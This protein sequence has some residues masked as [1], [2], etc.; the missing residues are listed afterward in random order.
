[1]EWRRKAAEAE[2]EAAGGSVPSPRP[3]PPKQLFE[4][5]AAPTAASGPVRSS[6]SDLQRELDRVRGRSMVKRSDRPTRSK[7]MNRPTATDGAAAAESGS[8]GETVRKVLFPD[9]AET[10][11]RRV[12]RRRELIHQHENPQKPTPLM[13]LNVEVRSD[14]N[15]KVRSEKQSKSMNRLMGHSEKEECTRTVRFI[16]AGSESTHCQQQG[17]KPKRLTISI[18][19][20]C[21]QPDAVANDTT[22]AVGASH[23][24][25]TAN[26]ATFLTGIGR[27]LG[28]RFLLPPG[29]KTMEREEKKIWDE[30][31][32]T[33]KQ[34]VLPLMA[35][36]FRLN[37][38][39]WRKAP[40]NWPCP[41]QTDVDTLTDWL[42]F[43]RQVR[44]DEQF[45]DAE[46]P[47]RKLTHVLHYTKTLEEC[48]RTC[49]WRI[50]LPDGFYGRTKEDIPP[51]M[52]RWCQH[53]LETVPKQKRPNP[54]EGW[55]SAEDWS[56]EFRLY[57]ARRQVQ[58]GTTEEETQWTRDRNRMLRT[59]KSSEI[60]IPDVVAG[61]LI[62][63]DFTIAARRAYMALG[64]HEGVTR[65]Y[66]ETEHEMW[67]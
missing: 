60:L 34:K 20:D 28:N 40:E 18:F 6:V 4:T 36:T 19:P 27:G 45:A 46:P 61:C 38:R 16:P 47:T 63:R 67:N 66:H 42:K 30:R 13:D 24:V 62:P 11:R 53:L 56:K 44:G 64:I 55:L 22:N 48:F 43:E 23:A 12:Q 58:L 35:P 51:W 21:Q 41:G 29:Y 54:Y 49:R 25:G 10:S 52:Q 33:L 8:E 37:L 31:V 26:A 1:M 50:F 17:A 65:D 59:Q 9:E 39:A 3:K 15:V 5:E 2:A 32:K 7:S 57:E 14:L